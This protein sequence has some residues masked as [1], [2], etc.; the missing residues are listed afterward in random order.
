MKVSI[1]TATYNSVDTLERTLQSVIG[2]SY[3]NIE[4]IIIDGGSTDGTQ[5]LVKRYADHVAYFVSEH[6]N[7]I[8]DAF[9][10]GIRQAT[11]DI[12]GI[13]NSDDVLD[14]YTT[15]EE[16][17]HTMNVSKADVLYGDLLYCKQVGD[18]RRVVRY[19]KSNQFDPSSLRY[20]WMPPHPTL[21]CKR[22][23]YERIGLYDTWFR[24]A[25]DYDFMLRLFGSQQYR[26]VYLPRVL[27][28]MTMGGASNRN[29]QNLTTKSK[30]DY[31]A[32]RK[33]HIGGLGVVVCKQV[34]K[35]WQFFRAK[36]HVGR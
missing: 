11:G 30:E 8:Y 2:Q 15:I 19:W 6:D 23:V 9:N 25:A 21:Y 7:G 17:V 34:R 35:I 26:S 32:V 20:G 4:L 3:S 18:D 1:I 36:L 13:L 22:E 27:V 31:F 28:H 29:L 10:K 14:N 24:I 33:N 12:I 5:D 16:I